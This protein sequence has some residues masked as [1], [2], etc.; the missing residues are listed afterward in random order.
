[1]KLFDIA[2]RERDKRSKIAVNTLVRVMKNRIKSNAKKGI[3]KSEMVIEEAGIYGLPEEL[4]DDIY[5]KAAEILNDYF[6]DDVK[7]QLKNVP[8][9]YN[10]LSAT[11]VKA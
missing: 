2:M 3:L 10:R 1:M 5:K 9:G 11:V 6:K 7:I 8:F 4:Y